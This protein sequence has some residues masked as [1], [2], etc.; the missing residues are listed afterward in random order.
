M[1]QAAAAVKQ[2]RK[3]TGGR[4]AGRQCRQAAAQR[5]AE[6]QQAVGKLWT[7]NGNAF[8]KRGSSAHP[9]ERCTWVAYTLTHARCNG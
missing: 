7:C 2:R 9:D 5:W 1:C 6:R 4:H 3:A 8:L